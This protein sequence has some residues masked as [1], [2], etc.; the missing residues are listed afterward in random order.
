MFYFT[1]FAAVMG[2]IPPEDRDK[3]YAKRF[4]RMFQDMAQIDPAD[5]A[6]NFT[7]LDSYAVLY[8]DAIKNGGNFIKSLV[9]QEKVEKGPYKGDYKGEHW[10]KTHVPVLS[11]ITKVKDILKE[12]TDDNKDTY[13]SSGR[14]GR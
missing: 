5:L 11:G 6:K 2:A 9:T 1:M 13:S 14:L 12:V 7:S 3:Q 10:L 4:Q 8:S